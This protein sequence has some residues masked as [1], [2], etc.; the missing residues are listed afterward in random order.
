MQMRTHVVGVN[1]KE[2]QS[3]KTFDIHRYSYMLALAKVSAK[4]D[5][6]LQLEKIMKN[7]F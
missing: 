5:F 2:T 6:L 4:N 7:L 1:E 3:S